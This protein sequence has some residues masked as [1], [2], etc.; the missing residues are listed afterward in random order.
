MISFP[1]QGITT[2]SKVHPFYRRRPEQ[3][4]GLTTRNKVWIDQA[5][6]AQTKSVTGETVYGWAYDANGAPALPITNPDYPVQVI[7]DLH[8]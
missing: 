1:S 2:I 6:S 7:V 3:V 5:A 4:L 8:H